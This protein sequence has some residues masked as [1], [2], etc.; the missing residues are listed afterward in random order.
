MK[1]LPQTPSKSSRNGKPRIV[2]VGKKGISL[3]KEKIST[4]EHPVPD[5]ALW[6]CSNSWICKFHNLKFWTRTRLWNHI[7]RCF[8]KNAV[9]LSAGR[10]FFISP[11]TKIQL[12]FWSHCSDHKDLVLDTDSRQFSDQHS[13]GV[14]SWG[15][16][17]RLF[18]HR[19]PL[20]FWFVMLMRLLIVRNNFLCHSVWEPPQG[21]SQ[22]SAP[23]LEPHKPGNSGSCACE[24]TLQPVAAMRDTRDKPH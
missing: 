9:A 22:Y 19:I 17:L 8:F 4:D 5:L 14:I 6:H 1:E 15:F 10:T 12:V 16:I 2:E 23:A 13:L 3:D 7:K 11:S 20:S 21:I 24:G 18:H